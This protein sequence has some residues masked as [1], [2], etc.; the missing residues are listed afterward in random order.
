M[1]NDSGRH[2]CGVNKRSTDLKTKTNTCCKL[3]L[4]SIRKNKSVKMRIV[5]VSW[6]EPLKRN[7]QVY[8]E[9]TA[10]NRNCNAGNERNSAWH[11]SSIRLGGRIAQKHVLVPQ[12]TNLH[13]VF[14]IWT[15]SLVSLLLI[16]VQ[17]E[18]VHIWKRIFLHSLLPE[19][20]WLSSGSFHSSLAGRG[21]RVPRGC[22]AATDL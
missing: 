20:S 7:E 22:T 9:W 8:F 13:K 1:F 21:V 18:G 4:Q 16:S 3:P 2:Y 19:T 10:N 5:L 12:L 15:H 6:L 14:V 17:S 11:Q